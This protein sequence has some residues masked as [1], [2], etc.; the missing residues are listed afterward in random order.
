MFVLS[1]M[2]LHVAA[3]VPAE[4]PGDPGA[5]QFPGHRVIGQ[6]APFPVPQVLPKAL[7]AWVLQILAPFKAYGCIG[8]VMHQGILELPADI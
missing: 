4:G 8:H 2:L 6:R 5:D 1:L 7:E 3:V